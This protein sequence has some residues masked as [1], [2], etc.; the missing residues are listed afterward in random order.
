MELA[1]TAAFV[2]AGFGIFAWSVKHLK[3]FGEDKAA[4]AGAAPVP[5]RRIPLPVGGGSLAVLWGLLT[6]GAILLAVANKS[7]AAGP[8]QRPARS[9]ALAAHE[10]ELA[11]PADF[12]FHE[13]E[14][15]PGKVT[16]S[17]ET[18]VPR[19]VQNGPACTSCHQARG[20]ALRQSGKTRQE[21]LSMARMQK[22]ELCGSCHNGKQATALDE[23]ALCHQ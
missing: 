15:S 17:H 2:A 20:F 23:C 19:T 7:S 9:A 4:P 8:V 13:G 12:A 6:V 1:V 18:H 14:G 21:A 5:G 22:G 11:L 10:A 16:F 3:V